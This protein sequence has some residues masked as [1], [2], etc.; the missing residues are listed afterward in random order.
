M[1]P[2]DQE[3]LFD[4]AYAKEL[5]IIAKGDL[6]SARGLSQIKEGRPE[7]ILFLI[8]QSMEKAFKAV[9]CAKSIPIPLV[10]DLGVLIA[11]MPAN[12]APPSGYSLTQFNQYATV[13]RYEE[14][15]SPLTKKDIHAALEIGEQVLEWSSK[16]IGLS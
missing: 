6:D 10:H 15:K 7:N 2:K 9:L 16:N 5:M 3:R 11:K 14:G 1:T 8:Q 4:P 13:R 12:L